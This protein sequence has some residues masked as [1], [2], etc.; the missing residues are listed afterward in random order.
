MCPIRPNKCAVSS[1]TDGPVSGPLVSGPLVSGPLISGPLVSG[2][3]VS[4]PL[5]SGVFAFMRQALHPV[6]PADFLCP[7][8]IFMS[9]WG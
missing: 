3:L 2:P 5:V 4:G 9:L 7:F 1:N 8:G 6:S